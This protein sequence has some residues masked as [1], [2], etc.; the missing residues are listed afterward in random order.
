MTPVTAL[1]VPMF[2]V[3]TVPVPVPPLTSETVSPASRP[4][5]EP[6]V[7]ATVVVAL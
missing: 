4:T 6:P 7:T 3:A 5:S 2:G 1:P